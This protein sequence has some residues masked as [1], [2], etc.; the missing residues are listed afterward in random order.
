MVPANNDAAGNVPNSLGPCLSCSLLA[1][2]NVHSLFYK[3]PV[4]V[5]HLEPFLGLIGNFD[6]V[7]YHARRWTITRAVRKNIFQ[8]AGEKKLK[9]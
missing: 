4:F 5:M 3:R 9:K 7:L 8:R 1:H 6:I 2:C